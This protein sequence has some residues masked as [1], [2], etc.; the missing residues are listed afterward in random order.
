MLYFILGKLTHVMMNAVKP[1]NHSA[2]KKYM[3]SCKRAHVS[4]IKLFKSNGDN[5][6]STGS[7]T[8]GFLVKWDV[9]TVFQLIVDQPFQ[10][11]LEPFLIKVEGTDE[12]GA[13]FQRVSRTIIPSQAVPP[14]YL[15]INHTTYWQDEGKPLGLPCHHH[16]DESTTVIWRK[17]EGAIPVVLEGSRY[18]TTGDGRL[19]I[20]DTTRHDAGQYQCQVSNLEGHACGQVLE[21]NIASRQ[22]I[23]G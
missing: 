15:S 13:H 2:D 12:N 14:V 18:R 1:P 7:P 16:M 4:K 6:K 22:H 17:L 11:P 8:H 19:Y 23:I 3:C 9:S 21:V 20:S 10:G 5:F